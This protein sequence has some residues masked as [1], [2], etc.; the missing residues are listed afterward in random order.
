MGICKIEGCG[1]PSKA[2]GLCHPHYTRQRRHGHPLGGGTSKGATLN[3]IQD[4]VL[5]FTGQECL[6]WPFS[7]SG[8]GYPLI[9]Y[10]GLRQGAHR[11]VCEMVHGPAPTPGHEA[12]HSCGKGHEGCINPNHLI[13]KTSAENKADKIAHGTTLRGSKNHKALLTEE[14]VREIRAL[15]GVVK[16]KDL[17]QRFSVSPVTITN[18][19]KRT[20]WAWL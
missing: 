17:A 3:Y 20:T 6:P 7:R 12:A 15:R 4:V 2:R 11:L 18:I 1:R 14:Q 9:T 8:V 13:W 5:P 16:G 19:Q 10:H